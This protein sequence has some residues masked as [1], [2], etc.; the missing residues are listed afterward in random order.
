MGR[1]NE[2][3]TKL[4]KLSFFL[5]SLLNWDCSHYKRSTS[6]P[7]WSEKLDPMRSRSRT[8]LSF[9]ISKLKRVMAG[10]DESLK[11]RKDWSWNIFQL[12]YNFFFF[13]KKSLLPNSTFHPVLCKKIFLIQ[14]FILRWTWKVVLKCSKFEGKKF[15][16]P[17]SS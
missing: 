14:S 7:H 8:W 5:C 6:L 4:I 10:K 1:Q 13:H 2:G 9:I 12:D 11:E 16:Q 15:S 17:E 3:G